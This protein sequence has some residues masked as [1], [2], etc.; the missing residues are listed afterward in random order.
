MEDPQ[1]MDIFMLVKEIIHP[2]GAF[3]HFTKRLFWPVNESVSCWFHVGFGSSSCHWPPMLWQVMHKHEP[4]TDGCAEMTAAM[5]CN[6]SSYSSYVYNIFGHIW[7]RLGIPRQDLRVHHR[8]PW[9]PNY[10]YHSDPL[11]DLAVEWM[12]C[13]L[14]YPAFMESPSS[15]KFCNK[16]ASKSDSTKS[17][18]GLGA[19]ANLALLGRMNHLYPFVTSDVREIG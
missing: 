4:V 13:F 5:S 6:G 19:S 17:F 9:L 16:A 2:V 7:K 15:S 10:D 8:L 3:M 1:M 14:A 18:P 11:C 12:N